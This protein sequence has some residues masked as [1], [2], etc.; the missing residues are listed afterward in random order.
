MKNIINI[1]NT[2]ADFVIV[3]EF[4]EINY[5]VIFHKKT[6]FS[7]WIAAYG[8]DKE[9]T[10]WCQGHYFTSLVGAMRYILSQLQPITW[11]R[12]SEIASI[13]IDGLITDDPDT[14][15]EFF[16]NEMELTEEEEKY[17]GIDEAKKAYEEE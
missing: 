12:I 9:S 5:V 7:E 14:A 2:N 3:A 15:F 6:M 1:E 16:E 17:F 13:A 8:Y 11:D 10:S 4:P